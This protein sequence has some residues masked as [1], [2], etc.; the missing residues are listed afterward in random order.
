MRS[1]LRDIQKEWQM[2]PSLGEVMYWPGSLQCIA[3]LVIS[4][5]IAGVVYGTKIRALVQEYQLV[6]H[7]HRVW[8][9]QREAP[10][11]NVIVNMEKEPTI[12]PAWMDLT[13]WPALL[14]EITTQST[15]EN[16]PLHSI[17]TQPPITGPWYH[18]CPME[19]VLEGSYLSCYKFISK[20]ETFGTP[21]TLGDFS[22]LR[23]ED[24]ND[25]QMILTLYAYARLVEI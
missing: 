8:K 13:D 5:A 18:L 1:K 20:L 7:D 22:I 21:M 3:I 12:N 25:V 2:L 9:E 17:K 15:A 10:L 11:K 19:V 4:V 24:T 16:I 14:T 23:R 6:Q